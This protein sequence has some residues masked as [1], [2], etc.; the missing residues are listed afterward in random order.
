MKK[1]STGIKIKSGFEEDLKNSIL[2]STKDLIAEKHGTEA[3]LLEDGTITAD[4]PVENLF[5]KNFLNEYVH[6]D[7][8]IQDFS[9]FLKII[10]VE[11]A[12]KL[13]NLP[14][15]EI[16]LLIEKNTKLNSWQEFINA[17]AI[18]QFNS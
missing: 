7:T 1:I 16:N 12:E 2:E 14:E 11:T 4:V 15:N 8:E 18:F 5:T 6:S 17:A 3:T 13:I 10:N 9:D